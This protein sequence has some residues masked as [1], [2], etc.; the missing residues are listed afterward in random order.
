MAREWTEH[1][2]LQQP[3]GKEYLIN[4]RAPKPGEI[5]RQ[6]NLASTFET[7]AAEGTYTFYQ[8]ELAKKIVSFVRDHDGL[9]ESEDLSEFKP[10]WVK[11]ISVEYNGHTLYEMPPNCQGLCALEAL[12]IASNFEL[13]TSGFNSDQ[14]L[15][16]LIQSMKLA[17][18]DGHNVIT[19]PRFREIPVTKMI[20]DIY[21]QERSKLITDKN[22]LP[23]SKRH[24]D[25]DTIYLTIIDKDRNMVS[26]IN[27][28]YY[29]FGSGIV[30]EGTGIILQNRGSAFTLD[31]SHNNCLEPR[32]RPYH[33]IIPAM[34][35]KDREPFMSFG[36]I[37]GHVQPQG[38]LQVASNIVNFSMNP[39]DA[40]DAPRFVIMGEGNIR[41]EDGFSKNVVKALLQRGH[42][43]DVIPRRLWG[44]LTSESAQFGGGQMIII[45]RNQD[46]LFAGS[47]PRKDGCAIGY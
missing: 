46:C 43:I 24:Q 38:H 7:I 9:L 32:K 11:P 14:Y 31:E 27:S 39:Q 41:L 18:A 37:G 8:G 47:D 36:V 44:N 30:V 25:A 6:T 3:G 12:K 33:T 40:L 42:Q 10:E 13:A 45:D 28:L 21:C 1:K 15:H 5:F 29:S 2:L 34:M 23:P 22:N 4:G 26:F 35:F 20:S 17:F 16:T 19:D